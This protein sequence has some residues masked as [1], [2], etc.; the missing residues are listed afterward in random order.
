MPT[1]QPFLDS[2]TPRPLAREMDVTGFRCN[3][4]IDWFLTQVAHDH[5]QK[6]ISTVTC[7]VTGAN[8]AGYI[9]TSMTVVEISDS[10]QRG[11]L[12]LAATI[13]RQ[14]GAHTKRFPAFLIGM[15]GV[16]ERYHR[17]GLGE[18]MVK[19][20]I[21]QARALSVDVGCRFVT[22]D[23]DPTDEALGLYRKMDFRAIEGQ[24][25]KRATMWMYYD[26]GH[27]V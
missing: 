9:A 24:D 10:T 2:L 18:H 16:C 8:I 3:P 14:G 22:V 17:R 1:D 15:L 7:W 26:I 13:F 5:H 27:R 23:S 6:R 11:F 21:G 12:G 25:K 20:A 19:Y 4:S